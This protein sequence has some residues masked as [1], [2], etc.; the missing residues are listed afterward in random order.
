MPILAIPFPLPG[1]MVTPPVVPAAVPTYRALVAGSYQ[2]IKQ[3]TVSIGSAINQRG[4]GGLTVKSDLGITW[5]YGTQA[6]VFDETGAQIYGGY[7]ANDHAYRD[8]GARQGDLGW[9][10]HDLTLMD[11]SYRAD[12]RTVFKQYNNV[13]AG[14]IVNDLYG[15]YLAAEGVTILPGSIATGPTII[16]AIW[17][18]SKSVGE[19]LTWLAQQ[20]GYWWTID[21]DGVLWFQPYGGVASPFSIDGTNADS[22]Q[23]LTVDAGN[24]LLVT[25]QYVKGS[26]GQK[27]STASPLVETFKGDGATRS[28][29]LS[30]PLNTLI[31]A[32]LN[33]LD[34]TSLFQDKGS[35]GG[36]YYKL[37]GDA[38]LAQD[39]SQSV[40]T[41]SDSLVITYIGQYPVIAAAQKSAAI[42]TQATRERV[43]T[44]LVESVHSDSKLRSLPAAFQVANNLVTYNGVDLTVLNFSTKQKGLQPGQLLPVTLSDYGLANLPMLIIA[45]NVSDQQDGLTIWWQVTAVGAPGAS[46][47]ALQA[48]QETTFWQQIM[49]PSSDPSDLTD[50]Q[51]TALALLSTSVVSHTPSVSI[52]TTKLLCSFPSSSLFPLS[53]L[54]PC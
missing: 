50:A 3:G 18:G 28:F 43:G 24:D 34:I 30:Y 26:V 9:L 42:A 11:N 45:V 6:L 10:N 36:A 20:S 33:A 31:S 54:F 48:A 35:S 21:T 41:S 29:T 14:F 1:G 22:M 13:T 47:W 15:A 4:T 2:E 37:V 12:K 44:G 51:D 17:G 8:A 32:T 53:S 38:V 23:N 5:P 25:K 40:L 46:A 52:T 16:Q 19:A 7:V 39:P 27:G 49:A